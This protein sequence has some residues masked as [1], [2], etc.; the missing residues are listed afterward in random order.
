MASP[1]EFA[2]RIAEH[3]ARVEDNGNR[4]KRKATLAIDATLVLATPVDTG[5]ARSNWQAN[6]G[7]S[8]SG[9]VEATTAGQALNRNK[10]VVTGSMPQ[11]AIHLT[12][13]L[14]YI[15]RL[16]EGYSAQA[17]AGF[18]E[19]AVLN[20]IRAVRGAAAIIISGKVEDG[21]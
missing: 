11:Q 13:N 1:K 8:A 10:S 20:G 15:G 6:L 17:P 7:G 12:N 14:P 9:E 2:R 21:N 19:K 4:I 16:N 5:R 3:A 18:V